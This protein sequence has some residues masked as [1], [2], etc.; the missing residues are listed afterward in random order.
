MIDA[1]SGCRQLCDQRQIIPD[2]EIFGINDRRW[3]MAKLDKENDARSNP[4]RLTNL[5]QN[6]ADLIFFSLIAVINSHASIL[7]FL[8]YKCAFQLIYKLRER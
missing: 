4:S 5:Y 8:I 3:L 6:S 7:I 2:G 1:V